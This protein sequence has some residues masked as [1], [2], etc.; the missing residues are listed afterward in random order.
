MTKPDEMKLPN[1]S[2]FEAVLAGAK[3]AVT[4]AA[5]LSGIPA[6]VLGP[7]LGG[8]IAEAV[9]Y[10]GQREIDKRQKAFAEAVVRGLED[11]Q[12]QVAELKESFWTTLFYAAEVARRTHQREKL[13]ALRNAVLNVAAG[14]APDENLQLVFLNYLDTLTPLHLTLLDCV[15]S[16]REWAARRNHPLAQGWN[17]DAGVIFEA[18]FR[19]QLPVENFHAQLLQDLYTRGLVANDANP[20]AFLSPPAEALIPHITDLGRRFLAFI[21]SPLPGQEAFTSADGERQHP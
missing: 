7:L 19:G 3:A 6:P 21:T 1:T 18:V 2:R 13:Q 10:F 15:A 4:V 8:S 20:N 16:P 17:P 14:T 9:G 11:M 5:A 12:V